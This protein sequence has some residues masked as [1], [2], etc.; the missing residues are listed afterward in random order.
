MLPALPEVAAGAVYNRPNTIGMTQND[1]Q[2]PAAAG[3]RFRATVRQQGLNP[4]VDVPARVSRAF[5]AYARAG[6]IAFDGR[7]SQAPIRGTL[8]PVGRG[9]HLLYVNGGMRSAAGVGTGDKVSVELWPTR[10]DQVRPPEDFAAALRRG[11]GALAAFDSLSPSHRRELLRYLDDARTPQARQRRIEQTIAH[12]LGQQVSAGR[13]SGAAAQRP[14]W[15]CPRCGNQFVNRNQQHSCRR[16]DLA[17]L[18]A[19]QPARIRQLFERFRAMVESCGPVKLLPYRDKVGFMVRV[20]FAG[21]RPRKD[22]LEIGFCLP[23]RIESPRFQKIE[24]IDPNAHA[25]LLRITEPDQLDAEVAAWLR[26]AYAVGCQQHLVR[27][28]PQ[29]RA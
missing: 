3:E 11:D 28:T 23:R 7:L 2:A 20:R 15:T 21:A 24:T 25:H 1:A 13:P 27:S 9:R 12:I 6:R 29:K 14:L 8:V 4:Y 17:A 10:P 26:E 18:F 5:A 19:G 16:H 22:W